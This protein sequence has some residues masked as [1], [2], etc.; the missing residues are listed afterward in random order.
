MALLPQGI[1]LHHVST[2]ADLAEV[3]NSQCGLAI[4]EELMKTVKVSI[5][6]M[7]TL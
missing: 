3:L 4:S 1:L 2:P 7:P 5:N 6:K